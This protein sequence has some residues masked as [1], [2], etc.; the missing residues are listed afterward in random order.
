MP[1]PAVQIAQARLVGASRR[2]S[3]RQAAVRHP[4]PTAPAIRWTIPCPLIVVVAGVPTG[5]PGDRIGAEDPGRDQARRRRGRSTEAP[6]GWLDPRSARAAGRREGDHQHTGDDQVGH[7]D[8]AEVAVGQGAPG[9]T[10]QVEPGPGERLGQGDGDVERSG[11]DP[12][13]EQG[14]G[15][16]RGRG[17]LRRRAKSRRGWR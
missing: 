8:P 15:A 17:V 9:V 14:R 4:K 16:R 5:K 11:D 3:S 7:L 1:A 10:G 12:G 6:S 2:A 13:G